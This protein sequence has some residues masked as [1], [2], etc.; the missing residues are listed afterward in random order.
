MICVPMPIADVVKLIRGDLYG[1]VWP[2]TT[3]LPVD[4][5]DREEAWIA[6]G[7]GTTFHEFISQR[8]QPYHDVESQRQLQDVALK[9]SLPSAY[10]GLRK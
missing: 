5:F 3:S 1:V 8:T 7:D 4:P 10:Q 2:V 6:S 9:A